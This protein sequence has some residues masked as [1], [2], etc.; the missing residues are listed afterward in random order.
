MN[1]KKTVLVAAAAATVGLTGIGGLGVASA[2]TS[3]STNPEASLIDKLVSKFDLNRSE[4][5]Q[6]L[7]EQRT[8]KEAEIKQ[9]IEDRLD[10]AVS[11]GKLTEAQK[12]AIL[13][14]LAEL[15]EERGTDREKL[16]DMT[17]EERHEHMQQKH[18]ELKA[19][20]EENDIP[21]EYLPDAVVKRRIGG[22]MGKP[23]LI[24]GFDAPANE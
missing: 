6:V 20:A 5:E 11:D 2:A 14:K 16:K 23:V 8:E 13:D 12:E 21:E 24:D 17:H 7:E 9:N 1:A 3:S 10:E 15:R 22:G 19:W 18:A 4:V